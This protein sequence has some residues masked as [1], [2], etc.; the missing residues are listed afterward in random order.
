MS[1]PKFQ[2]PPW[3]CMD[4]AARNDAAGDC[5][6]CGEG[7]LVDAREALV[8]KTLQDQDG[9][10]GRKRSRMLIG[11]AA[12]LGSVF[13]LPLVFLLGEFVGLV[14]VVLVGAGIYGVLRLF[15][16]YKPRFTDVL[17]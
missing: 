17:P 14:A 2:G 3:V 16:S 8:R 5:A 15:F 10:L 13:G 4:C 9:E 11:A 6:R 1:T 12:A 7:P